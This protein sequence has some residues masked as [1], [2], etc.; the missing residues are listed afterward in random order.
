MKRYKKLTIAILTTAL[1]IVG[2]GGKSTDSF[3]ALTESYSMSEK[4]AIGLGDDGGLAATQ[5]ATN[6]NGGWSKNTEVQKSDFEIK[7]RS[8]SAATSK[9]IVIDLGAPSN[10]KLKS[11]LTSPSGE[12]KPLQIGFAR[13]VTA[14]QTSDQTNTALKWTMQADGSSLGML[15]ITSKDAVY[16]RLGLALTAIP[17]A[18]TLRFSGLGQ[19]TYFDVKAVDALAGIAK[20]KA[21]G[22][23]SESANLY[24]S[25]VIESSSVVLEVILPAGLSSSTVQISAP[26]VMHIFRDVNGKVNGLESLQALGSGQQHQSKLHTLLINCKPLH[27]YTNGGNEPIYLLVLLLNIVWYRHGK[28]LF[29]SNWR[30]NTA[31]HARFL[32]WF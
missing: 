32:K 29:P 21:A 2:C 12:L 23:S 4:T 6:A 30:C 13:D 27:F 5:S 7:T 28:K 19:T 26:K 14:L 15:V 3:S 11:A 18:A 31:V 25:P 16:T 1:F 17:A 22:D 10:E 20:N 24:W 8:A 9:A